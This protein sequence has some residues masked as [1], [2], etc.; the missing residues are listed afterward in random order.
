MLKKFLTPMLVLSLALLSSTAHAFWEPPY[1]TPTTPT[2]GE[3]V[4]VNVR[5]GVCDGI[6]NQP[7]FPRITQEG[8]ALRI[9][10]YGVHWE[11]GSELC[12]SPTGTGTYPIGAFPP[13]AYTV[14]FDLLY[15]DFFS[16]PQILHL[17]VVPFTVTGSAQAAVPTP[18]LS[19][20]GLLALMLLLLGF[21]LVALR[22]RWEKEKTG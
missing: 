19:L 16:Q 4:S 18:S 8:N 11:P 1:V 13:G 3:P 22:S 5:M 20:L 6:F 10:V 9:V 17:G 14:T 2:A 7:G 15:I 21:A 12:S